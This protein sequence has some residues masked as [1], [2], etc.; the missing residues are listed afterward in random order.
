VPVLLIG[1]E[2]VYPKIG[3]EEVFNLMDELSFGVSPDCDFS[4]SERYLSLVSISPALFES[5]A[6]PEALLEFSKN[7][8]S[9]C[10]ATFGSSIS[11]W[12]ED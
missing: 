5:W 4:I 8:L 7:L 12:I 3:A 2:L 9:C 6:K 11:P 10:G 1:L